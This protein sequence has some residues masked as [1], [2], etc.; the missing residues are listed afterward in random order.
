MRFAYRTLT[1][2]GRPSQ[3]VRLHTR[4]LTPRQAG[5]PSWALPQPRTRNPRRVSHAHGLGSSAFAHHYSRNHNLFSLPAGTEMF[6][7]P[8]FPPTALYIQTAATPHDRCQVTPFG[9]P[10]ITAWL[11]AP[12]GISQAP[13]SFI[14]SWCQGIHRMPLPTYQHQPLHKKGRK[15]VVGQSTDA[16]VHY[17]VHKKQ[18]DNHTH[19][20]GQPQAKA[21][22]PERPR[23]PTPK[24]AR[25]L[26]TQQCAQPTQAPDTG[27]STPRTPPPAQGEA[28]LRP[29][30][31]EEPSD[32]VGCG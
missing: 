12:R 18:P 15:Q 16:R 4:F 8:A 7:F 1:V 25:F 24:E 27:G 29:L 21:R 5:G 14:G 10:R 26:R 17:A 31:Q 3:I 22:G 2:Y 32:T 30:S 6:H 20:P 19:N 28:R 23:K 11:P 9:N 13:T